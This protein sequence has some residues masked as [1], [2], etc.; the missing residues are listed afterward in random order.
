MTALFVGIVLGLGLV[1]TAD[2]TFSALNGASP[3]AQ[4]IVRYEVGGVG[5]DPHVV[6][7][8]GELGVAQLHPGGALPRFV[9]WAE[10]Q[11]LYADPFNPHL[12]VAFMEAEI[13]AGLGAQWTP[14]ARCGGR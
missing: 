2:D 6:G 5:W 3:M 14:Y 11:G 7:R 9:R 8:A 12:A 10:G 13:A 1:W 4:C